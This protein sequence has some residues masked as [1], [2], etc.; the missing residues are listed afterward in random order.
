M[1]QTNATQTLAA[2]LAA[3]QQRERAAGFT[4]RPSPI[5]GSLPS[6]NVF[7]D[8]LATALAVPANDQAYL[9]DAGDEDLDLPM[10]VQANRVGALVP[11][12]IAPTQRGREGRAALVGF[13]LGLALLVPIA[14]VMSNRLAEQV[15]PQ[16]DTVTAGVIQALVPLTVTTDDVGIKTTRRPTQTSSGIQLSP[17]SPAT[18]AISSPPTPTIEPISKPAEPAST[19]ASDRLIEGR[20]L[21]AQGDIEAARRLLQSG[22]VEGNPQYLMA[23]AETFDP[24][25]LAAWSARGATADVL[26]ARALYQSAL[27]QGE[28]K[29]RQR[30]EALD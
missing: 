19:V 13:G 5:N 18:A 10:L 26:R 3:A 15:P 22:A 17:V 28:S 16:A 24:N 8:Q 4:H 27:I 21:I 25:M 20:E 12:T 14:I 23:L 11:A 29:A 2:T 7:L 6:G 30:L 9:D 1:A